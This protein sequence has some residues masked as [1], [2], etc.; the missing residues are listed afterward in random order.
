MIEQILVKLTDWGKKKKRGDS[1]YEPYFSKSH[2]FGHELREHLSYHAEFD[3]FPDDLI[4]SAAPN[5]DA[6][7]FRYRKENYKQVTKP[8]WDKALSVTY[9]IFNPQN[10]KVV[11]DESIEGYFTYEY[12]KIG[13]FPEF[14]KDVIHKMKF[15][16]PNAV[17]AVKP[18]YIPT[19]LEG[20][21][22]KIDQSKAIEPICELFSADQVFEFGDYA[23]LL[24]KEKSDIIVSGRKRKEGLVFEYYD[25]QFI[26]RIEQIGDQKDWDF[27][28]Y[29]YYEHGWGQMPCWK[30]KGIPVYDPKEVMYHSHFSCALPNLD[31]AAFLNSTSFGVINKVA[32]PTRW[33]YEDSC[34]T[35]SGSGMCHDFEQTKDVVCNDCNGSGKKFT[36]TF[37]KDFVIPMPDNNVQQDTTNLPAPPFGVVDPPVASIEFLDKKV[38]E[39]LDTAFLNLNI[40]TSTKPTGTTATEHI[41]DEDELIS[42]LMQIASEEFYLFEEIVKAHAYM[43]TGK[44]DLIEVK[45]PT[46]FRIRNSAD[47]TEELKTASE[48]RLPAPYLIKLLNETIDQRFQSDKMREI[49]DVV[50]MVDPLMTLDPMSINSLAA[51]GSIEKWQK[52]LHYCIYNFLYLK[53]DENENYLESDISLIRSDME[54]MAKS[55]VKTG[56]KAN[57][58]LGQ[59]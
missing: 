29:E 26:Y 59:I 31:Q 48:A 9:R 37:G 20:D 16:D 3:V 51:D 50:A 13:S 18:Y 32:F 10:Y 56:T 34:S 23:L 7:E 24:T 4:K 6:K 11:F 46:E 27:E 43:M 30:L 28:A 42:F 25:E 14:F 12:P 15:A 1:E 22:I 57:D 58:I 41:I 40:N 5:E 53:I 49:V 2:E 36:F 39:L 21:E 17:A 19:K 33:Y 8:V 38:K 44:E 54:T 47:L 55:F 45:K 35:C 52:T